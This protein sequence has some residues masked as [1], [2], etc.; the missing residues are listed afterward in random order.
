MDEFTATN[1]SGEPQAGIPAD[2]PS[3]LVCLVG[4]RGPLVQLLFHAAGLEDDG[5]LMFQ[6]TLAMG[7]VMF[8]K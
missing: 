1:Y 3:A 7:L 2:G 5:T 4:A 8:A 6:L